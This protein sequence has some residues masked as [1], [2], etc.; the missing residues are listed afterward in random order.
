MKANLFFQTVK[1]FL[2]GMLKNDHGHIITVASMA[3]H[4][5]IHKLVDY[6]ASKFAA[7]SFILKNPF[8]FFDKFILKLSQVGFDESLRIELETLGAKNVQTT[9]ICPYFIQSTGMFD[10]VH[11]RFVNEFFHLNL[12]NLTLTVFSFRWVP[13]L[14]SNTVA[15]AIINGVRRNHKYVIIPKFFQYML[16]IKWIFPWACVSGFLRRLVLDAAPTHHTSPQL[17]KHTEAME[18]N[19]VGN[20]NTTTQKTSN[21]LVQRNAST[22][23]RVL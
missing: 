16:I 18:E 23:E 8:F 15:D 5:G 3:G 11:S 21:L 17:L 12:I 6:C 14:N 19:F 2:P 22:A 10:D 7:V 9:V 13:T 20:N 4:V 1:A